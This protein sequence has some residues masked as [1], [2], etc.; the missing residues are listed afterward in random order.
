[1]E[2]NTPLNIVRE[3]GIDRFYEIEATANASQ[4]DEL[5]LSKFLLLELESLFDSNK[6]FA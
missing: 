2:E 3:N 6:I 1:M 4:I 5:S